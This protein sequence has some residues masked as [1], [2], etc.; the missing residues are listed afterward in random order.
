MLT[1]RAGQ[2]RRTFIG[3]AIQVDLSTG[4]LPGVRR[5]PGALAAL[6]QDRL[7]PMVPTSLRI[8]AN[9]GVDD[10]AIE[11]VADGATQVVAADPMVHGYGFIHEI[12]G[13][14]TARG[15]VGGV[16]LSSTGLAVIEHVD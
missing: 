16:D 10:V 3:P 14:F 9:N 15:R 1:V 4:G 2:V 13:R 12:A 6:H 5:L 7:T 8:V 11:F